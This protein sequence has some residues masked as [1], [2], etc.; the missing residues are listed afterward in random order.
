MLISRCSVYAKV[1]IYRD[2]ETAPQRHVSLRCHYV[3]VHVDDKT[4]GAGHRKRGGDLSLFK[5]HV[6]FLKSTR[7]ERKA[8]KTGCVLLVLI[9]HQPFHPQKPIISQPLHDLRGL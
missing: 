8:T 9:C 5:E 6:F 1:E 3:T 7:K 2:Y 4:G